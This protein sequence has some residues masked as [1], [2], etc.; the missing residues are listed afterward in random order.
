MDILDDAQRERLGIQPVERILALVTATMFCTGLPAF[1]AHTA[2]VGTARLSLRRL[3]PS[4]R[5]PLTFSASRPACFA[6]SGTVLLHQ[7]RKTCLQCIQ[8][9]AQHRIVLLAFPDRAALIQCP[10]K[11]RTLSI[12]PHF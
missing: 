10:D 11:R 1:R 6:P 5:S 7:L 8:G 9:F 12:I 4:P 2:S 3:I